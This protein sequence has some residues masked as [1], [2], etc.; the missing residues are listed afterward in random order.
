MPFLADYAAAMPACGASCIRTQ[1]NVG[2][3]AQAYRLSARMIILPN[4]VDM[5]VWDS[6]RTHS[7]K[8]S[9]AVPER[10][11]SFAVNTRL[12]NL[13]RA[14]SSGKSRFPSPCAASTGF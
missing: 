12:S 5:C 2:R 3:I 8:E 1:K 13:S 7:Y 9:V 14:F 10:P 11:V 6:T 4:T